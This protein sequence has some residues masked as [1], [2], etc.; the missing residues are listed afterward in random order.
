MVIRGTGKQSAAIELTRPDNSLL[1]TRLWW[2]SQW[3]VTYGR[4][5]S[6]T[7]YSHVAPSPGRHPTQNTLAYSYD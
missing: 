1:L 6:V 2:L 5:P 3:L 7:I 4:H